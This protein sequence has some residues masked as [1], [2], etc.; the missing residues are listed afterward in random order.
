MP[1]SLFGAL[2]SVL[3]SAFFTWPLRRYPQEI[4]AQRGCDSRQRVRQA[5]EFV[6]DFRGNS[7]R[8]SIVQNNSQEGTI[9]HELAVVLDKPQLLELVHEESNPR[10]RCSDH[11]R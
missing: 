8:R 7:V 10:T 11:L 1:G 3:A 2:L 4:T 6:E 9:D 5:V